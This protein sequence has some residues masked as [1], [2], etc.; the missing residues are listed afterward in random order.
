MEP[1][2]PTDPHGLLEDL[3]L[4]VLK[5][6]A[7]LFGTVH[8]RTRG[9]IAELLRTM[10]SYYSNLIEGHHTHPIDIERA[11]KKDYSGEPAK[12]TLQIESAAH[13][14]VQREM[15]RRLDAEPK[16]KICSQEF[17]CWL[18]REFYARLPEEMRIVKGENGENRVLIPGEIRVDQVKVGSHVAP[19]ASA[20]PAFLARFAECYDLDKL[21]PA[22]R[23]IAAAAA[24]HRLAWIHPFLDGNGRVIRLFSKAFLIGIGVDGHGLWAASRGLARG[25]EAYLGAL[26]SADSNRRG[27]LDGRGNL[28]EKG[29]AL[30]CEFY[31]KTMLDQVEFMASL[32]EVDA[33]ERRIDAYVKKAAI[34]GE[35]PPEAGAVI[36]AVYLRGEITRGDASRLAGKS[37]RYGNAL[38]A[39]LLNAGFLRSESPK[40]VLLFHVPI[41]A[42]GYYFPRLY[43]AGVEEALDVAGS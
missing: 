16:L 42:V 36:G 34:D 35:L 33:I 17:L 3:S 18:H 6:S 4:Q 19:A 28:S 13:V 2:F 43:P 9:C 11:L 10:N 20:L 21:R 41:R 25:R 40:G 31:L 26:S 24:H 29:L 22:E 23:L 7:T 30:F 14:E 15:E 5:R 8:P 27:D 39:K 37:E 12:R 1:L 32:L 38:V